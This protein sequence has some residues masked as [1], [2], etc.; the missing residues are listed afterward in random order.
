MK[1]S[2]DSYWLRSGLFTLMEK[3]SL[4]LFGFG[5]FFFLIKVLTK[6]EFGIWSLFLIVTALIEMARNGLIQNA[7]VKYLA[8]SKEEDAPKI[9]TASFTLNCLLTLLSITA[10]LILPYFLVPLWKAPQL[11]DMFHLYIFTTVALIPFSQ[12]TF[13]Q[14]ARMDFRAIFWSNFCRQ[15]VIFIVIAG[16]YYSKITMDLHHVVM[17]HTFA[18]VCASAL[19]YLFVRNHLH[20]S[21]S[22]EWLWV[23]KLFHFGKYVFGTNISSIL[24]SSVDQFIILDDE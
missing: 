1:I 22:I 18:A 19:A 5:S 2:K 3:L 16:A 8:S 6:E 10:L 7:L 12:F 17:L 24:Y 15:G 20:F 4:V 21:K 14:Q 11:E 13:I 23:G 9:I